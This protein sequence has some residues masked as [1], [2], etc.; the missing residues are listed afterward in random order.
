MKINKKEIK[1]ILNKLYKY[2]I[3]GIIG[4]IIDN[5][6]ILLLTL[7]FFIPANI[8]TLISAEIGNLNNFFIN[9]NWTFKDSKNSTFIIRILKYHISILLGFIIARVFLFPEVFSFVSLYFSKFFAILIAN[10]ASIA[11]SFIFNFI[12]NFL[13]T[14]GSSKKDIF[15]DIEKDIEQTEFR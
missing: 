14:W 8:A 15:E 6:V 1:K 4:I 3:V 13:W 7:V 10:N 11:V 12:I 9:D 5:G 2:F